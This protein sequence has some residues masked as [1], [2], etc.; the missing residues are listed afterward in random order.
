MGIMT[1]RI[2]ILHGWTYS[3]DKWKRFRELLKQ[4]GYNPVFIKIPGLTELTDEVWDIQKYSDWFKNKLKSEKEKVILLGHS[5]GGRI[6]AFY[7]SEHPEKIGKLI[8][9]DSAGVYHKELVLQIK[10]FV[11]K[12]VA[13][14]GKLFTSSEALKNFMYT[15]AGERDYQNASPDMKQSMIN[16]SHHDLTPYLSGITT[17]TLII[18][19]REDKVTP[20]SD[21]VLMNRL[22]KGSKLKIIDGARH[23]PF[24]THPEKLTKII[25]DDI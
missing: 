3:L 8:L 2:I 17:P 22:I 7:A 5:N 11:F 12:A 20:L 15:L 10:R 23:S 24:Y 14:V 19:G 9:V 18:W 13:K 1:K 25:K 21:A 6:A 4:N 16:L